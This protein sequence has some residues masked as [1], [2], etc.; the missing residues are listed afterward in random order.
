MRLLAA[1]ERERVIDLCYGCRLCELRCPYT[2]HDGHEFQLDFPRLMAEAR[3]S[4]RANRGSVCASG[5]WG[6]GPPGQAVERRASVGQLGQQVPLQRPIMEKAVGIHRHKKL[7]DFAG[8][9]FERWVA[10]HGSAT[11]ARRARGQGR[12]FPYLLHQFHNPEPGKAAVTVFNKNQCAL[13][14]PQQNCCGMP[15]LDGGDIEFAKS[16]PA[17]TSP[18]SCPWS[19]RAGGWRRSTRPA[20]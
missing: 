5:C 9:T 7:P 13:A 15:A 12:D 10:K 1:A 14:C 18:R 3:R 11:R 20:G 8:E 19:S 2:P 17:P 16:R 6:S 4:R